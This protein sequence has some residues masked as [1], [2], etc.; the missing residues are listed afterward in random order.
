V[1]NLFEEIK[2]SNS[3]WVRR[4]RI[5]HAQHLLPEDIYRFGKIGVIASVQP[6]HCIDDGVWAEKRIGPERVKTTHPYKSLLENN[7]ALAFGTDW[8]VAPLN[9]LYGIFAAVTRITPDGKNP[10]GWNPEEKISV[11]DAVKCYTLNA[12]YASFEENLKGSIEVGKFADLVVLSDDILIIDPVKI[13]N[14]KIEMTVFD[15]EI[16]YERTK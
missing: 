9:P 16:V 8:P 11:E 1:L 14:V 7:T 13:K 2:N 10:N 4:F 6:Y 15:G 5:E 3:P 12:A